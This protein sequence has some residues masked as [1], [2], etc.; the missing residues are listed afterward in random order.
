MTE[1]EEMQKKIIRFQHQHLQIFTL[2]NRAEAWIEKGLK[3]MERDTPNSRKEAKRDF[4]D[5][6]QTLWKMQ[7][8]VLERRV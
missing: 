8:R 1:L 5:A 7:N 3:N 2:V 6:K 4:K